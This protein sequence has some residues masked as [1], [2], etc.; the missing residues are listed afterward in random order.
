MKTFL[1]ELAEYYVRNYLDREM[2]ATIVFPNIRAGLFFRKELSSLIDKPIW[3]PKILGIEDFIKQ[4]SNLEIDDQLSLILRLYPIHKK[5]TGVNESFD[6]FYFWGRILLQ[7][8]EDIDQY[9]VDPGNILTT[10]KKLKE[11][12]FRFDYLDEEQSELIRNFWGSV[13]N[14]KSDQKEEFIKIWEALFP[15]YE[16][17]NKSLE[18]SGLAYRGKLYRA[19]ANETEKGTFRWDKSNVIFAGFNAFSLAE[20]KITKWFIKEKRGEIFWDFDE[21]YLNNPA[22]QAGY[23]AREYQQDEI[24]KDTFSEKMPRNLGSTK[25]NFTRKGISSKTGQAKLCGN[26]LND[27]HEEGYIENPEKT[28]IVLPDESLLMSVLQSIPG[29]LSEINVTMGYPLKGTILFSLLLK[30]LELQKNVRKGKKADWF[31]YRDVLAIL[32]HSFIRDLDSELSREITGKIKD[33]NMIQVSSTF[34]TGSVLA[35]V[36]QKI[37][38]QEQLFEYM[39]DLIKLIRQQVLKREEKLF[40]EIFI[41][42]FYKLLQRLNDQFKREK[43]DLKISEFHTLFQQLAIQEKVPFDGEPLEG[44]QIMG[45]LETRNLDFDNVIVLSLNEGDFPSSPNRNS[46]VPYNVRKAF[47]IPGYEHQDAIYSYLFYR[48]LQRAERINLLYD[49]TE[50]KGMTTGEISRFLKQLDNEFPQAPRIQKVTTPIKPDQ[51]EDQVIVKND[52]VMSRLDRY[53]LK[54]GESQS[55]LNPSAINTYL[56]CPLTFFYRYVLDIKTRDEVSEDMDA[57][58]FGNILHKV[59]EKAYSDYL[60]KEIQ[61]EEIRKIKRRIPDLV[62]D[63]FVKYYGEIGKENFRIEGINIVAREIIEKYAH[64]II[65]IDE[66]YAPFCIRGLEK[67]ISFKLPF[68]QEGKLR[69]VNMRGIIDRV[70]EKDGIIR[71][72]DY[73]TG[74]DETTFSSVADLFDGKKTNRNKAV[75][76]TLLYAKVYS[77]QYNKGNLS[78]QAGLFNRKELMNLDFNPCIKLKENR[79]KPEPVN[80]IH[81]LLDDYLAGLAALVSEIFHKDTPF[82]HFE[83]NTDCRYCQY[84]G[85]AI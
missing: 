66:D 12:D 72:L 47:G 9:L 76:Q 40:D 28:V 27:W 83:S 85:I 35:E 84:S 56:D 24:F 63:S 10:I 44:I 71:I 75:M 61:K 82:Q 54:N 62:F 37:P 73:K 64:R 36:F 39:M 11:I 25:K 48:L 15:I 81:I 30:L 21:Y 57:A 43:I 34:F 20:E 8:F 51:L 32:N 29:S 41:V 68:D 74:R 45:V 33:R 5:H 49:T 16:D 80:D 13:I 67:R 55:M 17:F 58:M 77:D 26:I 4:Q 78:I 50:G 60:D 14:Q 1:H 23:F 53:L 38:D 7:D 46:F 59:M 19:V 3:A 6:R 18:K 79:G 65:N 22:H 52:F 69:E 42:R 2:D 70:D 31:Y